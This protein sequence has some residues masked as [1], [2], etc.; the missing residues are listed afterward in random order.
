MKLQIDERISNK[1]ANLALVSSF[2]VVVIHCRPEFAAGTAGWW[3]KQL[4]ECGVCTLAVPFFF[5]A[6]GFFL[7]GH[8][9]EDGWY[10]REFR[11]RL[12]TLLVPYLVWSTLYLAFDCLWKAYCG[13]PL[14]EALSNIVSP[15]R[16]AL[17]Y[18]ANPAGCPHLSPLWYVRGLLVLV[19]LAPLLLRLADRGRPVIVALFLLCTA[20]VVGTSGNWRMY[21]LRWTLHGLAH[22]GPLPVKG[23]FYF[24]LGMAIRRGAFPNGRIAPATACGLFAAG[25]AIQV[26]R[27]LLL[28]E[29]WS[30][31]AWLHLPDVIVR[32]T[33]PLLGWLSIPFL[34]GGAWGWSPSAKWPVWLTSCSFPVYLVHK[35]LYPVLVR[36]LGGTCEMH[37][38]AGCS[39]GDYLWVPA[40]AFAL[41]VL[42]TVLLRKL[43]PVAAKVAFGGR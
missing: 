8:A 28:R 36:R 21:S 38:Y 15:V 4:L 18:G 30:L 20:V 42:A 29:I 41:S 31:P 2:L 7:A 11:K 37:G 19:A 17:F 25:L 40:T 5:L 10:G 13:F 32:G 43:A 9:D 27:I 3:A 39:L 16:L 23:I 1:F 34:V 26:A 33:Q 14:H 12:K 6:S 35:F 22:V 24:T